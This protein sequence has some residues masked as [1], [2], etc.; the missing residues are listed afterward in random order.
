MRGKKF[1]K[2]ISE[3]KTKIG[4]KNN[5]KMTGKLKQKFWEKSMKN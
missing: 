1:E 2:N 5:K 3:K 4:R